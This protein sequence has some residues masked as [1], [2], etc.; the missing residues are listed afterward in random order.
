MNKLQLSK[1][2]EET[3]RKFRKVSAKAVVLSRLPG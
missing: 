3:S 1:S 2:A